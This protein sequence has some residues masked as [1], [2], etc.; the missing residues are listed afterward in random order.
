[1]TEFVSSE[2]ELSERQA[3]VIVAILAVVGEL[4]HGFGDL[5]VEALFRR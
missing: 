4:L 3:F 5:L 1:M 2:I